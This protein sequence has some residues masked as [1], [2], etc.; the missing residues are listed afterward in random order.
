MSPADEIQ[1]SGPFGAGH[2][3]TTRWSVVLAAGVPN[4]PQASAALAV[5]C[6]EYWYP[7]YAFVR[8]KGFGAH[9]AQDLTQDFFVRLLNRNYLQAAD[10]TRGRFRSFLLAAIQHFLSETN[11]WKRSRKRGG[12]HTVLSLDF[13]AA[14]GRYLNEPTDEATPERLYDRRWALTLLDRTMRRLAGEFELAGKSGLFALL[15]DCLV[16][17]STANSYR[18]IGAAVGMSE[19]AVKVAAHRLRRRFRELLKEE[20]SQTVATPADVEAEL[21]DLFAV[22]SDPR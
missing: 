20:I 17:T 9:E 11:R 6:T 15:K 2:F 7:L 1:E 13:A 5:L 8:R 4:S 22:L 12:S 21:Q 16:D 10:R 18:E 3:A 14:E 19:G